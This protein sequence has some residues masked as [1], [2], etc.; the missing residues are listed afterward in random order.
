[1]WQ[2]F[3]GLWL[4]DIDSCK[5]YAW[6]DICNL[7]FSFVINLFLLLILCNEFHI[8]IVRATVASIL[9]KQAL[10]ETVREL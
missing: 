7:L 5:P 3:D 1:M 9:I 4:H 6:M 8:H 10:K 2:P